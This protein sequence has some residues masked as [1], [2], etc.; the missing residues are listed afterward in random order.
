LI[1][2]LHKKKNAIHELWLDKTLDTYPADAAKFFKDQ[3]NQFANPVGQTIAGGTAATL[4]ALLAGADPE[5]ICSHLH[6]VLKVR[7]VQEFSAARAVGFVFLLKDAIHEELAREQFAIDQVAELQRLDRQIDQVALF[8]FDMFVK[9]REQVYELRL[10]EIKRTSGVPESRA[11]RMV[12]DL[13]QVRDR[14]P[15]PDRAP[16]N[17]P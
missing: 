10:A 4:D 13:V 11:A 17:N 3:G 14:V 6:D 16:D 12:G 9:C 8:A 1:E 5:I 2:L 7:A 15:A